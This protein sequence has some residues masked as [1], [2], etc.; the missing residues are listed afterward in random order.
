MQLQQ[1][2]LYGTDGSA[3]PVFDTYNPEGGEYVNGVLTDKSDRLFDNNDVTDCTPE[4]N[5]ACGCN[6]GKKWIDTTWNDASGNTRH[7]N[8]YVLFTIE[9]G[10]EII[11]YRVITA[12]ASLKRRPISWELRMSS[13]V[14]G[15]TKPTNP[16]GDLLMHSVHEIITPGN[17]LNYNPDPFYVVAPPPPLPPP[18]PPLLPPPSPPPHSPPPSPPPPSPPP[19]P[20]PSPPPAPPPPSPPPDTCLRSL[21]VGFFQGKSHSGLLS[22]RYSLRVSTITG[23]S[24]IQTCCMHAE[25]Q[26]VDSTCPNKI[27]YDTDLRPTSGVVG[28]RMWRVPNSGRVVNIGATG[29]D[30]SPWAY[31][32]DT[33]RDM[34]RHLACDMFEFNHFASNS[35]HRECWCGQADDDANTN[36]VDRFADP[37]HTAGTQASY[38]A[39]VGYTGHS[40]DPSNDGY[41]HST[42]T[43]PVNSF[44]LDKDGTCHLLHTV[45]GEQATNLYS[46][47]DSQASTATDLRRSWECADG[48]T[49]PDCAPVLSMAVYD[50]DHWA[51]STSNSPRYCR[52]G[53]EVDPPVYTTIEFEGAN[54]AGSQGVGWVVPSTIHKPP[55]IDPLIDPAPCQSTDI[56]HHTSANDVTAGMPTSG[57]D[58]PTTLLDCMI[59]A[60]THRN[61]PSQMHSSV[62]TISDD[63]VESNQDTPGVCLYPETEGKWVFVPWNDPG[64]YDAVNSCD[65]VGAVACACPAF[66]RSPPAAA[67]LAA[68][69]LALATATLAAAAHAAVAIAAAA[70][71]AAAHAAAVAIAAAAAAQILAP[72]A[73]SAFTT[74]STAVPR[75][76]RDVHCWPVQLLDLQD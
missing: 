74:G 9:Q 2:T 27:W 63:A 5:P 44:A 30:P 35:P 16:E 61:D 13:T 68:A 31:T 12:G 73:A 3:I 66:D 29:G 56:N 11:S 34:C 71:A 38:V 33:C 24:D 4:T 65:N 62:K 51:T 40:N 76:H 47:D 72:A 57:G 28:E 25:Q 69:A 18:P 41:A 55:A 15:N 50:Q 43:L 36:G 14:L 23:I 58:R 42:C 53:V 17:C 7:G 60:Q 52:Q 10:Q 48:D 45:L 64:Y 75:H 22:T 59:I 39:H 46:A 54:Y 37:T 26:A 1:I 49:S 21:G 67:A 8:S 32:L 70:H 19:L 6:G 20:P